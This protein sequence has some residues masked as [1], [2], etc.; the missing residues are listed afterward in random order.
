MTKD[1]INLKLKKMDLSK[2]DHYFV[3][4]KKILKN[5]MLFNHHF[6]N[7][8]YRI[9]KPG[10]YTLGENIIFSPNQENHGK[11]TDIQL[12]EL[13]KGF[14]LGFFAAITIECDNVILN[15]N[16]FSISQSEI[17]SIQQPF[18][19]HI[20]LA[21]T[22][23]IFKQGPASFP[24]MGN[25]AFNTIIKNGI[26]GLSSH[27]GIHGNNSENI[28]IK[29]IE[30]KKFAVA[31]IAINGGKNILLKDLNIDN[32]D[33]NI[34]FN[35]LLSHALFIKP[36]L[37]KI[38]EESQESSILILNKKKNIDDIIHNLDHEINL[39][40]NSIKNN[41]PYDGLFKNKSNKYDANMYGIVLNSSGIVVN[42]FKPLREQEL[43]GNENIV[44]ENI[45]MKNLESDGTEIKLLSDTE[46]N[47]SN[48]YGI[49]VFK[50][51]VGDVFN[52][53]RCIDFNGFYK[54]NCLSNAQLCVAL[55][56]KIK[57]TLNIPNFLI[58]WAQN[59]KYTIYDLIKLHN[60]YVIRGGDSMAHI[61]KGN[62]GLFISQGKRIMVDSISIDTVKNNSISNQKKLA[63]SYGIL[64]AGSK[65]V[66]ITEY[67]IKN[68]LSKN[69]DALDI[70]QKTENINI[71]I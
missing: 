59:D 45:H 1:I 57:S 18:Y 54:G 24:N 9:T 32:K 33:I 38:K 66:M 41:T 16:T 31:A 14:V 22:P 35:S 4:K 48:K 7:G 65:D 64:M 69:G 40:L 10:N 42:D 11:P 63:S 20:E 47:K 60:L 56:S 29:N 21:N 62:I 30:F 43:I 12:K 13:P 71:K 34:K 19:S 27:H 70:V 17:H 28:I 37:S 25:F 15:L 44:L 51:P 36:F 46:F 53:E 61:M 49:K 2:I 3:N 23:F 58:E 50:G 6:K 68:I 26:L 55:H 67:S 39:A 8:T 5:E 52:W